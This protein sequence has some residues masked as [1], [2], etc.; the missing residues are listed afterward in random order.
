MHG[1]PWRSK[2]TY[3]IKGRV[4]FSLFGYVG[5]SLNKIV[6]N[7]VISSLEPIDTK[8]NQYG[9][10]YITYIALCSQGLDDGS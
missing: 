7:R 8:G 10:L 4:G 6:L 5:F 9:T 3:I 2:L 1:S